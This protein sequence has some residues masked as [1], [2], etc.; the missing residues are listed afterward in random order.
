MQ[1][2]R[3]VTA[4]SDAGA[5]LSS[6]IDIVMV[7]Y[8]A[9]V[10]LILGMLHALGPPTRWR[11]VQ[12]PEAEQV[13]DVR[14]VSAQFPVADAVKDAAGQCCA[15]A[16]FPGYRTAVVSGERGGAFAAI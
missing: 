6:G 4:R 9:L 15:V 10:P 8:T 1:I 7:I 3:T 5:A 11:A 2:A 12:P 14:G 13:A 16:P